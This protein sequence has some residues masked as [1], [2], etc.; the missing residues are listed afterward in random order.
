MPS[1]ENACDCS[2][3]CDRGGGGGGIIALSSSSGSVRELGGL[4]FGEGRKVVGDCNEDEC[5]SGEGGPEEIGVS[6][7]RGEDG[8]A[9]MW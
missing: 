4:G 9:A 1:H 8:S 3:A 6:G 5:C 2:T 7:L